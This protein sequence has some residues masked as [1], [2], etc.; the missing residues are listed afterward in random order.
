LQIELVIQKLVNVIYTS[1]YR[2]IQKISYI[3]IEHLS[4]KSTL[5]LL[6]LLLFF[7]LLLAPVTFKHSVFVLF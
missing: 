6:L 5:L 2:D 3:A 4:F 1:V 7:N